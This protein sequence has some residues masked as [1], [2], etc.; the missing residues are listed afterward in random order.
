MIDNGIKLKAIEIARQNP[1]N[2]GI[3]LLQKKLK[4]GFIAC[5]MIMDML[6]SE[7]VISS[8]DKNKKG[9]EVLI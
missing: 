3:S 8:Y 2:F 1:N 9:R 5:N 6:E 4:I 7:G